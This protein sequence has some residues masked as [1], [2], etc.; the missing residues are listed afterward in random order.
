MTLKSSTSSNHA[1]PSRRRFG[2]GLLG[3]L[4]D[5]AAAGLSTASAAPDGDLSSFVDRY[6]VAI[7]YISEMQAA[8]IVLTNYSNIDD[9]PNFSLDIWNGIRDRYEPIVRRDPEL[10]DLVSYEVARRRRAAGLPDPFAL[11]AG[12]VRTIVVG[13]AGAERIAQ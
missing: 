2:A 7:S 4:V 1:G 10:R 11:R 12:G 9:S 8:G 5:S 6:R 13:A 3:S